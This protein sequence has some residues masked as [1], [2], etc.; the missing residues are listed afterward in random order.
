MPTEQLARHELTRGIIAAFYEV[1]N[2]LGHGF[3]EAHYALALERKLRAAG[4]RVAREYAIR[5]YF[6]GEELGFHRL[7]LVVDD[8]VVVEIK[9]TA[10]LHPSARRQLLNYLR[11]TNLEIGL[12]LNFGLDPKFLRLYVPSTEKGKNETADES[13]ALLRS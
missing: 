12:L 6:E 3:L 10:S 2:K 13:G 9:A 7:D 5:V 1:Y 4:R 8:S 11:A